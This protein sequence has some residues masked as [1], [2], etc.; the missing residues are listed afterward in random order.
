MRTSGVGHL[1]YCLAQIFTMQMKRKIFIVLCIY[2]SQIFFVPVIHCLSEGSEKDCE[3]C[4]TGTLLNSP[5]DDTHG[6]C[7]NP[8][9]HHH[10]GHRHDPAHCT[11]CKSFIKDIEYVPNYYAIDFESLILVTSSTPHQSSTLIRITPI[12]GPPLKNFLT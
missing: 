5:C 8:V 9:H 7:D 11:F 10:N 6:P 12:R 4:Y 3:D 2:L 1:I